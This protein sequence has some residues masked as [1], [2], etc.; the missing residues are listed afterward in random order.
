M[1]RRASLPSTQR[2][3]AALAFKVAKTSWLLDNAL[4]ACC[5]SDVLL[6]EG[7][8]E[9]TAWSSWIRNSSRCLR[10]SASVAW[11][12]KTSQ[13]D[14]GA[15]ESTNVLPAGVTENGG[16]SSSHPIR[17]AAISP[18]QIFLVFIS[19]RIP[20]FEHVRAGNWSQC[21]Y[22]VLRNARVQRAGKKRVALK[23]ALNLNVLRNGSIPALTRSVLRQSWDGR[24][25]SKEPAIFA[26]FELP[27]FMSSPGFEDVRKIGHC[28][29]KMPKEKASDKILGAEELDRESRKP[30]LCHPAGY[31]R[32]CNR[33]RITFWDLEF[34]L[35]HAK[36]AFVTATCGA[37]VT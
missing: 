4:P 25:Q 7:L 24:R 36:Q 16:I 13:L 1:R 14:S 37:W 21:T 10:H 30:E 22:L 3:T 11:W 17:L 6:L 27:D 29:G 33:S 18:P 5:L 35:N 26:G 20:G 8:A 31:W 2:A 12:E 23:G 9:E 28:P 19:N 32:R 15:P 34:L